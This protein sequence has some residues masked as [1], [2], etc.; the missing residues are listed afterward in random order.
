MSDILLKTFTIM[1]SKNLIIYTLGTALTVSATQ[2]ATVSV[3]GLILPSVQDRQGTDL[4]D[5]SIIQVGYL[6]GLNPSTDLNVP[7]N[8]TKIDWNSFVAIA[9]FGSPKSDGVYDTR[10][11]STFGPGTFFGDGLTFDTETDF[12][13]PSQIPVRLAIR[14][15]DSTTDTDGAL[16]NTFISSKSV[17]VLEEPNALD[18]NAGRGDFSVDERGEDGLFWQG[19]PFL[20]NVDPIPEPSTSISVL[21]GLGLLLGSRRR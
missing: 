7:E 21:L 17:F 20:T 4:V 16:F 18:P 11:S 2:A 10:I 15:F 1:T 6:L 12:G 8:S 9:G 14:V 13:T 5:N 3:G 19:T